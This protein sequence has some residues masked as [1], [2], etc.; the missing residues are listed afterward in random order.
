MLVTHKYLGLE[1]ASVHKV[2]AVQARGPELVNVGCGAH[3]C[4]LREEREG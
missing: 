4:K 1:D 2:L 3:V